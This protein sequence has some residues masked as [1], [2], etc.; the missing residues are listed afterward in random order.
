MKF[1][2]DYKYRNIPFCS[3]CAAHTK[4]IPLQTNRVVGAVTFDNPNSMIDPTYVST[5]TETKLVCSTCGSNMFKWGDF[6][7]ASWNQSNEYFKQFF[8]KYEVS[9][10]VSSG[11]AGCFL[12]VVAPILMLV[13]FYLSYASGETSFAWQAGSLVV[14]PWFVFFI[15]YKISGALQNSS[16]KQQI[17]VVT[18]GKGVSGEAVSFHQATGMI[19]YK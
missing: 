16:V 11:P 2:L 12:F 18:V 8:S 3:Q 19:N 13:I 4:F 9:S 10:D 7:N 14:V 6:A 1:A 15:Y 5:Q 17:N